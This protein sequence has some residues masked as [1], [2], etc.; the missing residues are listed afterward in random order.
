M[1]SR[2]PGWSAPCGGHSTGRQIHSQGTQAG[3][4]WGQTAPRPPRSGSSQS[5]LA[6]LP[7]TTRS[8]RTTQPRRSRE[9][10]RR[11][12]RRSPAARAARRP[13]LGWVGTA[14]PSRPPP[15]PV[16]QRSV[17]AEA[18]AGGLGLPHRRR[19][20]GGRRPAKAGSGPRRPTRP[21]AAAARS[22][23]R[24]RPVGPRWPAPHRH[25]RPIGAG[26]DQQLVGVIAQVSEDGLEVGLAERP[27]RPT[28]SIVIV[29]EGPG[30]RAGHR[31]LLPGGASRRPAPGRAGHA[32]RQIA[33]G[34][35]ARWLAGHR[36]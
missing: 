7:G 11:A 16:R 4:C 26:A 13:H 23:G 33:A 12:V 1:R 18:P 19:S 17:P 25:H 29:V 6:R 8:C 30:S 20:R 28:G 27:H 34:S 21:T 10:S 36:G 31:V 22:P 3:R 24:N 35:F 5:M 14:A 2:S 32:A 9:A 15:P